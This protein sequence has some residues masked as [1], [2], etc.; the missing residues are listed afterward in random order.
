MRGNVGFSQLSQAMR[1]HTKSVFPISGANREIGA[2]LPKR[3]TRAPKLSPTARS[4]ER[5]DDE[6]DPR[7]D[8][9]RGQHQGCGDGLSTLEPVLAVR[10]EGHSESNVWFPEEWPTPPP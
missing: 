6:Q 9:D 5:Y 4:A 8:H 7:G 10:L 3:E 1:R 2:C